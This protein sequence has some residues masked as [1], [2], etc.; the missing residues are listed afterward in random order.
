MELGMAEIPHNLSTDCVTD[1]HQGL[2]MAE[3][4]LHPRVYPYT[5]REQS[6][7]WPESAYISV[8]IL[9]ITRSHVFISVSGILCSVGEF[10]LESPAIRNLLYHSSARVTTDR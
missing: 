3:N 5:H 4:H 2:G 6:L 1:I 8:S 9:D 7:E 10:S